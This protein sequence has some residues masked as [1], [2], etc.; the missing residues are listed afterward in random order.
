MTHANE[1]HAARMRARATERLR[2]RLWSK[3]HRQ[4]DAGDMTAAEVEQ[5]KREFWA[6]QKSAVDLIRSAEAPRATPRRRF[7]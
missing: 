7:A 3:L 4:W 1:I 2:K 5:A 6:K